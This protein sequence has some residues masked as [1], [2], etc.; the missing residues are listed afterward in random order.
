[1]PI[2]L[3]LASVEEEDVGSFELPETHFFGMK[4]PKGGAA[5]SKCKFLS[6]DK[7]HCESKFFHEWRE[8]L[9]AE[10][11]TEIPDDADHYC[12]DVFTA[13]PGVSKDALDMTLF[14]VAKKHLLRTGGFIPDK[15]FKAK[16]AE[17]KKRLAEPVKEPEK[18]RWKIAELTNFL[19]TF[20]EE[21]LAHGVHN[22]AKTSIRD[23]VDA[24]K[25]EVTKVS[26]GYA[27]FVKELGGVPLPGSSDPLEEVTWKLRLEIY[28]IFEESV[29][30]VA[31]AFKAIWQTDLRGIM[32][33]AKRILQ[34]ASPEEREAIG[35]SY[36]EYKNDLFD[37]S[38]SKIRYD[39]Y[40]RANL[41]SVA[42]RLVSKEK[43]TWDPFKWIDF[44]A[45]MLEANYAQ[46]NLSGHTDFDL[47]GMKII[48]MD[49][50]LGMFDIDEYVKY[51][52]EAYVRLK[53]KGLVKAWYGVIFIDCSNC[54]GESVA[55]QYFIEENFVKVY[56]RP[57]SFVTQVVVHELGHRYWFKQMSLEQRTRFEAL[58]RTYPEGYEY[59]TFSKKKV[60]E[61]KKTI[62]SNSK[63]VDRA[64]DALD[65][66]IQSYGPDSNI[67]TPRPH[68]D[69]AYEG[70]R[71]AANYFAE[72]ASKSIRNLDLPIGSGYTDLSND[73]REIYRSLDRIS[74]T[75]SKF[76]PWRSEFESVLASAVATAYVVIDMMVVDYNESINKVWNEDPRQVAPVSNYGKTNTAE[77]FAE[78]FMHYVLELDMDRDQ[79]DSFKSVLNRSDVRL[80]NEELAGLVALQFQ[81]R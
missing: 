52:V 57:S 79:I 1:M 72:E 74:T 73:I 71:K 39:F 26:D 2:S 9:K 28:E 12:C 46:Q 20:A 30:T 11:P 80:S 42:K 44:L 75:P 67:F 59:E 48:V 21:L 47:H 40:Q 34:K 24:A 60:V 13:A 18:A 37:T 41:K 43:V 45:Q 33:A 81:S 68:V 66:A 27:Q 15:F 53:A 4:V 70:L 16:K 22:W 19:D 76:K 63:L 35:Q 62:D 36:N 50:S 54:G 49:S 69:N 56:S 25:R 65:Y 14:R 17:L 51:L 38:A 31:G 7:K 23:R 64:L 77:A 6:D 58:V 5:C 3:A 55:G 32:G 10:D 8:S 29:D 61:A 78:A